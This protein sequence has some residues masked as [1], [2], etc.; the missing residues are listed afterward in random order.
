MLKLTKEEIEYEKLLLPN[1]VQFLRAL[2][3]NVRIYKK[4]LA[5]YNSKL[6][7]LLVE[8]DKNREAGNL[9]QI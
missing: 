8:D 6:F 1:N 5:H 3:G 4:R 7:N 2:C 9:P